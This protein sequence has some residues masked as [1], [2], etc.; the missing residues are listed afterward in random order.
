MTK[1]DPEEDADVTKIQAAYSSEKEWV[2]DPKG[3]FTIRP[4]PKEKLIRVRYY[5]VVEG[6]YKKE[7][8]I[9][10]KT[11]EEIIQTIVRDK[12]AS[13]LQHV[14]YLGQELMKAEVAMELNLDFVQD[15]PLDYERQAEE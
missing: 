4:F 12:L 6:G 3:F 2:M 14:G 15:S 1:Y 7:L 9:E 5:N 11:A 13:S 10:G 8:L